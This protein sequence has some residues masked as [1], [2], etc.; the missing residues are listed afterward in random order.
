MTNRLLPANAPMKAATSSRSVTPRSDSA[1][2]CS[3]AT[4][5]SVRSSSA[6]TSAA[7]R[8]SPITA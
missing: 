6:S 1:A 3:P 2:S 8:S 7:V 5:P 4:Q